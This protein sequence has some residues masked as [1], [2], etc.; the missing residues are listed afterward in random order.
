MVS[1]RASVSCYRPS[2]Q[3]C[4]VSVVVLLQVMKLWFPK[5]RGKGS[6]KLWRWAFVVSDGASATSYTDR[7]TK[8]LGVCYG[9]AAMFNSIF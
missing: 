3:S 9:F 5:F 6:H 2:T 7:I 4:K 8:P 1:H